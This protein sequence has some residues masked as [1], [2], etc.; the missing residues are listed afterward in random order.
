MFR[1]IL[2]KVIQRR[3][4]SFKIDSAITNQAILQFTCK[5]AVGLMRGMKLAMRGRNPKGMMLEHGVRFFNMPGI[6]F[7]KFLKAGRGVQFSSFVKDGIQIGNNFSIGSYSQIIVST[8]L[9]SPDGF[10]KIGHGVG[11]GEFAY[12]GGA[13]GLEIGN[14]CI[15]GQYLSCHP[16]NHIFDDI[17]TPIKHQGVTRKGIS[18]GNNCWIG[19]KVTILDGVK[20]GDGCVI[21]AGSV[22]TRS[23]PE[24][25]VIAGVP[26]KIIRTRP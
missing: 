23:F 13:G 11:I 14:D 21:A 15:V 7:G 12:L 1:Q 17:T 16:E 3:N 20:I 25:C 8:Q 6:R 10:I 2:T 9:S 22:V 5:T 18:I 19:S 24:N 26:A 4:P